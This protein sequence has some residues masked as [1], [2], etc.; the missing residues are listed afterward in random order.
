MESSIISR[1]HKDEKNDV[2]SGG[3]RCGHSQ[4]QQKN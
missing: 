2:A 4:K 1:P 3:D